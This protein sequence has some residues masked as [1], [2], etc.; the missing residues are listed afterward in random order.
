MRLGL[1]AGRLLGALLALAAAAPAQAYV[2]LTC[3]QA[4]T[5]VSNNPGIESQSIMSQVA[6]QW[7]VQDKRTVALG[8][9]PIAQQMLGN[10]AAF[11]RLSSQCQ[12]NPGQTLS[13]AAA[14]VYLQSREALDGY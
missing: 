2:G 10:G 5:L 6:G 13:A 7:A 3:A 12:D 14:Q 8:Y 4:M 9:P 1:A 11:Q